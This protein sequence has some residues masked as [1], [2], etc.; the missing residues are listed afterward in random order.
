[1]AKIGR[2][3]GGKKAAFLRVAA[4]FALFRGGKMAA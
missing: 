1:M 3:K 4:N 2:K